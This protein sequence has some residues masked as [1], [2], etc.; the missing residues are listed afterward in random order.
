[1]HGLP[2]R[3][4]YELAEMFAES[5]GSR[6]AVAVSPPEPADGTTWKGAS[7]L[8]GTSTFA[9]HWCVH[10]PHMGPC[11]PPWAGSEEE[12][13]DGEEDDDDD[14]DFDEGEDDDDDDDDDDA[15][16][17]GE[18]GE[19]ADEGEEGEEGKQPSPPVD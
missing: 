19:E 9:E 16:E 18:E 6:S 13:E 3:L 8:A 10:A 1:M 12:Y 5:G 2:E 14:D 7:V 4:R 15:D 11:M 17:E